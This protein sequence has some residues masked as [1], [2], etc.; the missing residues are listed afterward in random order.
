MGKLNAE[1]IVWTLITLTLANVLPLRGKE[2]QVVV[3]KEKGKSTVTFVV[4]FQD[5]FVGFIIIIL[6][7]EW[8]LDFIRCNKVQNILIP[9]YDVFVTIQIPT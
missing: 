1:R 8:L 9:N 6:L 5:G 7:F 4:S 2:A 3:L